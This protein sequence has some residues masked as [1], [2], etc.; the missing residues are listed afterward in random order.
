MQASIHVRQRCAATCCAV[1]QTWR[2]NYQQ[3]Q[4]CSFLG[5]F[6]GEAGEITIATGDEASESPVE[7]GGR[8]KSSQVTSSAAQ[9]KISAGRNLSINRFR[10]VDTS[11]V[12][13]RRANQFKNDGELL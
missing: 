5:G 1:L 4:P 3:P 12:A 10:L 7:G 8:K 2:V 11:R 13:C 6:S 9:Q